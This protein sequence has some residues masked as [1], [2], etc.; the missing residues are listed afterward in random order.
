MDA[1]KPGVLIADLTAFAD[2]LDLSIDV[3]ILRVLRAYFGVA[4]D[5]RTGCRSS[6]NPSAAGPPCGIAGP[7][8]G[9]RSSRPATARLGRSSGVRAGSRRATRSRGRVAW[10]AQAGRCTARLV[11]S[12]CRPKACRPRACGTAGAAARAARA[13]SARSSRTA[14]TA[15]LR[16]G[17][18]YR[19]GRQERDQHQA[20]SCLS[21]CSAPLTIVVRVMLIA[22]TTAS[23]DV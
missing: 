20:R 23:R 19:R 9:G 21:H 4:R 15:T 10:I 13:C 2:A 5:R 11:C 6:V 17:G 12:S 16:R 1:G 7:P 14:A 3:G 8:D 22:L 18:P